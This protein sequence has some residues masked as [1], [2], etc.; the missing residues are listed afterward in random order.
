MLNKISQTEETHSLKQISFSSFFFFLVGQTKGDHSICIQFVFISFSEKALPTNEWGGG[1]A[2][3]V[4]ERGRSSKGQIEGR[5][6]ASNSPLSPI[7][8]PHPELL[9]PPLGMS[10]SPKNVG[11]TRKLA[12][13]RFLRGCGL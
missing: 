6:S 13:R 8:S 11:V 10:G 5:L 3:S 4:L 1:S 2:A 12:N 7:L 9:G